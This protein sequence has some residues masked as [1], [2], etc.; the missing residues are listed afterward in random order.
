MEL[1]TAKRLMG[2]GYMPIIC[3]LFVCFPYFIDMNTKR[4]RDNV[5]CFISQYS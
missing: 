1:E 5:I 3:C 2:P 4:Q